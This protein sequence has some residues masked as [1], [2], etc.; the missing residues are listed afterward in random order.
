MW[1]LVLAH[2]SVVIIVHCSSGI[3]EA[4]AQVITFCNQWYMVSYCVPVAWT[5][6]YVAVNIAVV[7]IQIDFV[8]LLEGVAVDIS[9]DLIAVTN[10]LS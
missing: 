2:N 1:S 5:V 8:D 4:S 9:G 10:A 7:L 6:Y 3:H